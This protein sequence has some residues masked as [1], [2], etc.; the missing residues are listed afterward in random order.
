MQRMLCFSNQYKAL[1]TIKCL[2]HIVHYVLNKTHYVPAYP[3]VYNI[4]AQHSSI[5]SLYKCCRRSV[6]AADVSKEIRKVKKK[7]LSMMAG[8]N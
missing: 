4:D 5:E 7:N 1:N 6:G 3:Q 8:P 2:V